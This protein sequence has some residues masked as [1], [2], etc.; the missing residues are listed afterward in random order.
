M[1]MTPVQVLFKEKTL[2]ALRKRA[3]QETM[4]TGKFVTPSAI[5]QEAV[6]TFL[7]KTSGSAEKG[8]ED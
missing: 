5:I 2:V 6:E 7:A 3:G 1:R 8:D 4:K